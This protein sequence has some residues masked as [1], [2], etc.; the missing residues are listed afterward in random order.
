[1]IKI[2]P[3]TEHVKQIREELK[4][5]G[6]FCPCMIIQTDDTKCPCKKFREEQECC[7]SLYI[8]TEDL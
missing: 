1:M 3:D 2:N 5:N 4:N 8:K 6:G 7:C